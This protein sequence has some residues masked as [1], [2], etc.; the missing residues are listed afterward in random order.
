MK[1]ILLIV[2]INIVNIGFTQNTNS[3]MKTFE[4]ENGFYRLEYPENFCLTYKDNILNIFPED[5]QSS[6]TVSSYHFKNGVDDLRF[7]EMFKIF[8][9]DYSPS[10]E[11]VEL[12]QNIWVQRFTEQNENETI[13]W[14]MSLNRNDKVLLVI[15]INFGEDEKDDIIDQY[16]KIFQSIVNLGSD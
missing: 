5:H 9:E 15:S 6:L 1:A 3:K 11:K 14:T 13:V 4:S 7:A 2:V 12:N 10:G 16:Q 8:T